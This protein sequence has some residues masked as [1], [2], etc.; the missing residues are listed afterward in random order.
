MWTRRVG[1]RPAFTVIELLVVIGI[2]G[3]V[4]SLTLPAVQSS[5]EAA[6]RAS[7]VNHLKQIGLAVQNYESDVGCFP[8][9]MT[10]RAPLGPGASAHSMLLPHLEQASLYNAINFQVPPMGI[11]SLAPGQ[12]NH[13]AAV[14][15]VETFVCPSDALAG[16]QPYGSNNYRVNTGLCGLCPSPT[17]EYYDGA[18][19]PRGTR[20]AE[21]TDGL[22]NTLAV[23]EKLVSGL[24]AYDPARDWLALDPRYLPDQGLLPW[25][26]WLAVCSSQ[27]TITRTPDAAGATWLIGGAWF[28]SFFSG[29]PPNTSI[30]DCGV[31][32]NLGTGVFAARSAHPGGV[33]AALADGSVRFVSSGIDPNIWRALGTRRGGELAQLGP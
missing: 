5:R 30:P 8:P 4:V 17:G 15:V 32:Y 28:T 24:G 21:F 26:E 14:Q 3:L 1:L 20:P 6:R 25:S 9:W 12:P 31:S 2:I 19:T 13:T 18:F 23:S 29:A 16:V 10:W 7:C 11:G 27:T 33:N 22:S